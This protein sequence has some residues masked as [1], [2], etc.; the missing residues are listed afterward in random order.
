MAAR[1]ADIT[2]ATNEKRKRMVGERIFERKNE[3]LK[4]KVGPYTNECSLES[5]LQKFHFLDWQFYQKKLSC[6]YI[7]KGKP[8]GAKMDLI[9]TQCFIIRRTLFNQR[10]MFVPFM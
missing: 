1:H 6:T 3:C 2:K 4:V 10:I 7:G 5:N 8:C 9:T